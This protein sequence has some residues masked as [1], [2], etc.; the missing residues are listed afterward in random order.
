VHRLQTAILVLLG[1]ATG[2]LINYETVAKA[3]LLLGGNLPGWLAAR[4]AERAVHYRKLTGLAPL[5]HLLHE[6]S[7]AVFF[8]RDLW[9]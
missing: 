9:R 3:P 8:Y 5:D 2:A 7:E 6:G 1:I 4:R